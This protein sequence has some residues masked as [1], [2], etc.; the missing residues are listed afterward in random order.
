[1]V[2]STAPLSQKKKKNL[3]MEP[4]S[5][6]KTGPI[7]TENQTGCWRTEEGAEVK[8]CVCLK[9]R[10]WELGKVEEKTVESVREEG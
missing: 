8:V 10:K 1:M 5:R 3:L 9:G 6:R 7:N 2:K 4:G